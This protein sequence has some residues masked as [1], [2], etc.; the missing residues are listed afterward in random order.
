MKNMK[1]ETTVQPA[2]SSY[3]SALDGRMS[4]WLVEAAFVVMVL[5]AV[6]HWGGLHV[7]VSTH[8]PVTFGLLE[9]AGQLVMCL[10]V[11]RGMRPLAHPLTVLWWVVIVLC[12]VDMLNASLGQAVSLVGFYLAL[13]WSLV[14]LPLGTLLCI[15]YRGRLRWLGV[16]MMLRVLVLTLLPVLLYVVLRVETGAVFDVLFEAVTVV[17]AVVYAWL[18]RT[19]LVGKSACAA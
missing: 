10:G 1:Q 3:V 6:C 16:W 15:W 11:M 12:I 5:S 9:N 4:R 18:F 17:L 7:W 2:S 14:Y 8:L 19:L 13:F